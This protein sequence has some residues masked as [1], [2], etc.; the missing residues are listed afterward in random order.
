MLKRGGGGRGNYVKRVPGK[1]DIDEKGV[2][3]GCSGCIR[4]EQWTVVWGR[5]GRMRVGCEEAGRRK[6]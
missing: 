4:L 3:E 1:D 5:G 6:D 2:P